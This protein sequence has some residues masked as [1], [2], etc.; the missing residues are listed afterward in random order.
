MN[1]EAKGM[2]E[3][4]KTRTE[5]INGKK[6]K[7]NWKRGKFMWYSD[8]IAIYQAFGESKHQKWFG[9]WLEQDKK[10]NSIADIEEIKTK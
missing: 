2:P 6:I 3:E 4:M 9:K 7:I 1:T 8:P 5:Y 10:F